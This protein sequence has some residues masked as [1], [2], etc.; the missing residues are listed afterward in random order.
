VYFR[1][2]RLGIERR[3]P[4]AERRGPS[5]AELSHLYTE[6]GLSLRTRSCAGSVSFAGP[7]GELNLREAMQSSACISRRG[8]RPRLLRRHPALSVRIERPAIVLSFSGRRLPLGA[9]RTVETLRADVVSVLA[10]EAAVG[11]GGWAMVHV[12][13]HSE[14]PAMTGRKGSATARCPICGGGWLSLGGA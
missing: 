1:L 5:D 4:V 14:A 7:Q 9:V 2:A 10:R 3:S 8:D 13:P 6:R 12:F 11:S